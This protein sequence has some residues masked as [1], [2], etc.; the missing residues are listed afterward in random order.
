MNSY[1]PQF[2]LFFLIKIKLSLETRGGREITRARTNLELRCFNFQFG[3]AQVLRA[4]WI[5]RWTRLLSRARSVESDRRPGKKG[6][7]GP[8]TSH[9][10]ARGDPVNLNLVAASTNLCWY[11]GPRERGHPTREGDEI[12]PRARAAARAVDFRRRPWDRWR[13]RISPIRVA[14]RDMRKRSRYRYGSRYAGICVEARRRSTMPSTSTALHGQTTFDGSGRVTCNAR[15]LRPVAIVPSHAIGG[16][17]PWA[18]L[19]LGTPTCTSESAVEKRDSRMREKKRLLK[20]K[21]H[22]KE[23]TFFYDLLN[24]CLCKISFICI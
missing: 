19:A 20:I 18:V 8:P 5:K 13:F 3:F 16:A 12:S 14:A 22:L 15:E 1:A 7:D 4:R 2:S 23:L 9:A 17:A 24:W 21:A 11:C 6:R 10:T